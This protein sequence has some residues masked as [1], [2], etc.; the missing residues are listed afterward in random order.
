MFRLE[1]QLQISMPLISQTFYVKKKIK[2]RICNLYLQISS[3]KTQF[4]N[5]IIRVIKIRKI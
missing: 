1:E 5:K 2:I 3:P 4:L